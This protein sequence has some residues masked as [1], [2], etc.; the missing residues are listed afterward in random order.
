MRMQ[1]R[2]HAVLAD[3]LLQPVEIAEQD[4][5]PVVGR[6]QD[7]DFIVDLRTVRADEDADLCAAFIA[8][9]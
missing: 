4:R 2:R 6:V 5:P 9:T 8:C 7:G 1:R 3:H